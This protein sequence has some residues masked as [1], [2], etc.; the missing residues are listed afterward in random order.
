MGWWERKTSGKYNVI[1]ELIIIHNYER[2]HWA[3]YEQWANA[4]NWQK[5]FYFNPHL[6]ERF[7]LHFADEETEAELYNLTAQLTNSRTRIS[8]LPDPKLLLPTD[9]KCYEQTKRWGGLGYKWTEWVWRLHREGE[10]CWVFERWI[11]APLAAKEHKGNPDQQ[12]VCPISFNFLQIFSL[13]K[14]FPSYSNS[15]NIN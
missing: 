5:R 4:V 11:G 6:H 8:K 13:M 14:F 15:N 3:C 9:I 12:M 2:K 1:N 7:Y 10:A